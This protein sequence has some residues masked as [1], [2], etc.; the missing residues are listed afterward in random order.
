MTN[1]LTTITFETTYTIHGAGKVIAHHEVVK[2]EHSMDLALILTKTH[3]LVGVQE[4]IIDNCRAEHLDMLEK[5]PIGIEC[6]DF[7]EAARCAG[8]RVGQEGVPR[9]ETSERIV[10][11]EAERPE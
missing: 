9:G 10:F 2:T 8:V 3:G 1:D 6:A 4:S 11:E 5:T 7:R